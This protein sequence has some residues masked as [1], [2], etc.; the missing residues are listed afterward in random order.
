MHKLVRVGLFAA[1]LLG[2]AV[3]GGATTAQDKDKKTPSI[4]EIMKK[5][6]GSPGLMSGIAKEA[7]DGKWE[8]ADNDSKLL[9]EFGEALGKNKAPK[10][11]AE[12]WKKLTDKYKDGTAAVAAAVE[13]KDK[14][15]VLA[16]LDKINQ[17]S[18]SCKECHD[19]HKGGKKK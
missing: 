13:K 10:G 7:R 9:K 2:F 11:D 8:D 4:K 3:A 17:K 6:H 16:A 14:D 15:A 1:A 5:G 19:T 12:S 18:G